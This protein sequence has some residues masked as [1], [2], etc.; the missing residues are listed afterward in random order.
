MHLA[1]GHMARKA[2]T[3]VIADRS[4]G[5]SPDCGRLAISPPSTR[6][7]TLALARRLMAVIFWYCGLALVKEQFEQ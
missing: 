6:I 1:L 2:Q 7:M 5:V 3:T 4:H